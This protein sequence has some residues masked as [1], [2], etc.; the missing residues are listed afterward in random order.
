MKC[1]LF[2]EYLYKFIG[3]MSFG[4]IGKMVKYSH[5][6]YNVIIRSE[7]NKFPISAGNINKY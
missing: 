5:V 3:K 4:K 1:R 6:R 7:M 2:R